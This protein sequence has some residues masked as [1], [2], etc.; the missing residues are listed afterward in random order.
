MKC[1]HCSTELIWQSD[2]DQENEIGKQILVT[3]LEC[4]ECKAFVEIFK[5]ED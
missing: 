4:P 2:H 3:H 1:W 5:E